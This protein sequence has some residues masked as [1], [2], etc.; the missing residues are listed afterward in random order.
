MMVTTV[1]SSS[2]TTSPPGGGGGVLPGLPAPQPTLLLHP[3]HPLLLPP[4]PEEEPCHPPGGLE[5]RKFQNVYW[6]FC[7]QDELLVCNMMFA[8][9]TQVILSSRVNRFSS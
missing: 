9:F 3:P 8:V 7:L 2:A 4:H 1:S 5:N 6:T